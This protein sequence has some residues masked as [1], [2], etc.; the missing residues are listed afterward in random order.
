[1]EGLIDIHLCVDVDLLLLG[2]GVLLLAGREAGVGVGSAHY[3][4][5]DCYNPSVPLRQ[6]GTVEQAVGALHDY[7]LHRVVGL[8]LRRDLQDHRVDLLALRNSLP[9]EAVAHLLRHQH[10]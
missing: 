4:M 7:V 5:I 3:T 8:L 9:Q 2:N 1:V 10:H 6:L